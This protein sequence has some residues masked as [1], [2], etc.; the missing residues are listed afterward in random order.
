MQG[1]IIKN[2]SNLYDVLVDETIYH[3]KPRGK[4]KNVNITPLVGDMVTI[5][6]INNYLLAI[7]PRTNE[8]LRPKVANIDYVII[9]TSIKH[10]DL[11]YTLLDK[12]L[13]FVL[14]NNLK[15]IIIFSKI[16]LLN[17]EEKQEFIKLKKYYSKIGFPVFINTD[18]KLIKKYLTNKEVVITGQ[19]GAGKSTFINK[20]GNF[21]IPTCEISH[22]LGRGKHTTRHV[23]IYNC[24]NIYLVDTPGFSALTLANYTKESIRDTFIEF[25]EYHCQFKDCFHLGETKCGVKD[26]VKAGLVLNSRFDSYQKIVKEGK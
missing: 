10:P 7:L 24:N 17:K 11:S 13:S 9:M 16:D 19:T 22:A 26:A 15:P 25:K 12:E 14:L 23:E 4:F 21:N 5:D 8:L 3:C 6:P 18:I 20:L 1:K 2:I